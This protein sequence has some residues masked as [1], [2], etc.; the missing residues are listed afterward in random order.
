MF[1]CATVAAVL[2]VF[3]VGGERLG[4]WEPLK[5]APLHA[6]PRAVKK[7]HRI[8]AKQLRLQKARRAY[9]RATR[10]LAASPDAAP[11]P[12]VPARMAFLLAGL[13]AALAA[14]ISV[15]QSRMLHR[16]LQ[17]GV[18]AFPPVVQAL[19]PT[20]G[21]NATAA[22]RPRLLHGVEGAVFS[23][24][25]RRAVRVSAKALDGV[26]SKRRRSVDPIPS[27]KA[28]TARR[29]RTPLRS[30]AHATIAPRLRVR[31]RWKLQRQGMTPYLFALA[32]ALVVGWALATH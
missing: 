30:I 12:P 7:P 16:V 32:V 29:A 18:D 11:G 26:R 4:L 22:P 1:C 14:L 27:R 2:G 25:A 13:A 3:A 9:A 17:E 31:R 5:P 15:L 19:R 24:V 23:L 20:R 28:G 21:G 6:S 10:S 8:A